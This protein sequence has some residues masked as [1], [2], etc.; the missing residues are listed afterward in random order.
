MAEI[1]IQ[2]TADITDAYLS[3]KTSTTNYGAATIIAVGETNTDVNTF[4]SLLKFDLSSIPVGSTI[5]SATL[6]VKTV[7]DASTNERTYRVYRVLRVWVEAQTTWN[8]YSTGNNWGTAGCGNTTSD[9]ESADIGSVLFTASETAGTVKSFTL[10]ADKV[11]EMLV[12][13]AFTNNG[14]LIK[15]DTEE[16]DAYTLHSSENGAEANNPKLVINYTALA[17][18][19]TA[20]MFLLF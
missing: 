19:A 2:A 3:S 9:R 16:N 12:D 17:T 1:T 10:T 20:G 4:R 5:N 18:P 6:S 11:Q 8:I 7:T 13:G 14:F 15:A